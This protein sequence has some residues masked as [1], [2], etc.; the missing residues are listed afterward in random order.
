MRK[1]VEWNTHWEVSNSSP[2]AKSSR[3]TRCERWADLIQ[4]SLWC[5]QDWVWTRVCPQWALSLDDAGALCSLLESGVTWGVSGAPDSKMSLGVVLSGTT[6]A[7]M[8]TKGVL[9]RTAD[10]TVTALGSPS[11]PSAHW[12]CCFPEASARTFGN[13]SLRFSKIINYKQDT[14]LECSGSAF[15]NVDIWSENHFL[16]H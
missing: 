15:E 14:S 12:T 11:S 4:S 3:I 6:A 13:D 16:N 8:C 7:R 5:D 9:S 1:L 10:V 2:P